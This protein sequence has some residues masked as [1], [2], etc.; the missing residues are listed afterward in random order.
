MCLWKLMCALTQSDEEKLDRFKMFQKDRSL[1]HICACRNLISMQWT[2]GTDFAWSVSLLWEKNTDLR[3]QEIWVLVLALLC[4]SS[5]ILGEVMEY[6]ILC[7]ENG[8]KYVW[9]SPFVLLWQLIGNES[10]MYKTSS[11]L[12][13]LSN[14]LLPAVISGMFS[15]THALQRN[16]MYSW[17]QRREQAC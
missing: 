6:Q 12:L 3:G 15:K 4:I 14:P 1:F 17:C 9:S 13:S 5:V 2:L 11:N 7:L 16:T 10:M 8:E